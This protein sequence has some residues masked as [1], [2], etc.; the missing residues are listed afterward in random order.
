[1]TCALISIA[2]V[3]FIFSTP[4]FRPAIDG[5][6]LLDPQTP[7]KAI[8]YIEQTKLEGRAFHPQIFGDYLIW[9]LYPRQRS[10]FDGRVHVF[11]EE[12]VREYREIFQDSRWQDQLDSFD[13]RYLLLSK[14]EDQADSRQLIDKAKTSGNWTILY[15]DA[16]SVLLK[17][18]R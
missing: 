14:A 13:I 5:A 3:T 6:A 4:W 12:L 16:I 15:E 7:V 9:R 8:D 10:F 1:L 18:R 11:G 2:L 17:R